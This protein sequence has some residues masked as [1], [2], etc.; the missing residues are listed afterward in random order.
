MRYTSA[1]R[2][3]SAEPICNA[4]AKSLQRHSDAA[5]HAAWVVLPITEQSGMRLIARAALLHT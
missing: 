4:S 3:S 1:L 5:Y 2:M